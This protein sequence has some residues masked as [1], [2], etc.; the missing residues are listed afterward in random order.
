MSP[1]VVRDRFERP[2]HW[3]A[4]DFERMASVSVLPTSN[5][6][7][8]QKG[9]LGMV[10]MIDGGITAIGRAAW[11]ARIE[12]LAPAQTQVGRKF[13]VRLRFRHLRPA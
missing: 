12:T 11:D 4:L 7:P 8:S 6:N 2:P 5:A 9:S 13:R 1:G 10:S 3:R